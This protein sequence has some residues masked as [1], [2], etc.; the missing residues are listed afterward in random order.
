MPELPNLNQKSLPTMQVAIYHGK[1]HHREDLE[2]QKTK[3]I[4]YKAYP[5]GL[6]SQ[7]ELQIQI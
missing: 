7:E 3:K 4:G 6:L 1:C 2:S 5:I